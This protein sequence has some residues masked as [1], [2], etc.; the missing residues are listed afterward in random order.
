MGVHKDNITISRSRK[1]KDNFFIF[2]L[3]KENVMQYTW[4]IR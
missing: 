3:D 4:V 1:K 2:F